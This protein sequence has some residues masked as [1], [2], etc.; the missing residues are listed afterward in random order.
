[1]N[2]A[3]PRGQRDLFDDVSCPEKPVLHLKSILATAGSSEAL[4]Q[5]RDIVE[6]AQPYIPTCGVY[7]LIRESRILYVGQSS[8]IEVRLATHNRRFV[9]DR[10]AVIPCAPEM[11]DVLESHYI[12]LFQPEG[13]CRFPK[14]GAIRAPLSMAK[15]SGASLLPR[16]KRDQQ[17]GLGES[18]TRADSRAAEGQ[19]TE[20]A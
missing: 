20:S 11:L 15:L 9:Y 12:H 19:R 18:F 10:A 6:A 14:S 2:L 5:E 4:L 8:N 3:N 13:N 7:F 17:S 1:M 16:I